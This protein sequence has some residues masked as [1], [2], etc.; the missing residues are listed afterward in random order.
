M[1]ALFVGVKTD[2][3]LSHS[4]LAKLRKPTSVASVA[5]NGGR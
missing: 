4:A 5:T 2:V 1:T 3:L